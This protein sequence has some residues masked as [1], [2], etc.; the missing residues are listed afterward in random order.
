MIEEIIDVL[1][2]YGF[3]A[4]GADLPTEIRAICEAAMA[5]PKYEWGALRLRVLL[6]QEQLVGLPSLREL[7]KMVEVNHE[8]LRHSLGRL[9]EQGLVRRDQD[10]R[11]IVRREV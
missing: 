10:G 3:H 1:R 11:Y 9:C 8:T 2:E 4:G 7:A 5:A 6:A